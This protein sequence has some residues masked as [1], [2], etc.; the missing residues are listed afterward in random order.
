MLLSIRRASRLSLAAL[1][2]LSLLSA[3]SL[4]AGTEP[5]DGYVADPADDQNANAP[6]DASAEPGGSKLPPGVTGTWVHALDVTLA[7]QEYQ[8]SGRTDL[9][10]A[11]TAPNRPWLSSIRQEG[12]PPGFSAWF[13]RE[14]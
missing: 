11:W 14:K 7:A 4:R 12:S 1:A 3:A 8:L 6:H 10:G 2:I 5:D 13:M 9:S